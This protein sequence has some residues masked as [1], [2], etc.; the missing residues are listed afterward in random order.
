M[1]WNNRFITRINRSS[2]VVGDAWNAKVLQGTKSHS[3]GTMKEAGEEIDGRYCLY[4][5]WWDWSCSRSAGLREEEIGTGVRRSKGKLELMRMNK[6][7]CPSSIGGLRRKQ[8]PFALELHT[9]TGK[10]GVETQGDAEELWAYLCSPQHCQ[11]GDQQ[12]C[13]LAEIVPSKGNSA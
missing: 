7:L 3:V 6:D 5:W 9:Q 8:T 12:Q 2:T 10:L 1:T 11:P 13:V 4:C